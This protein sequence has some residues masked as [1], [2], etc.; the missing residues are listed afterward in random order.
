MFEDVGNF[1]PTGSSVFELFEGARLSD[2]DR[3]LVESR[4]V[5]I[6]RKRFEGSLQVARDDGDVGS[7]G[8]HTD[9]RLEGSH[10]SIPSP[11]A[12]GEQD[13]DAGFID[14]SSSELSDGVCS[15]LFSNYF[16]QFFRVQTKFLLY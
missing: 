9:S 14:E 15:D 4:D 10:G 16:Q 11:S 13:V 7:G 1:V 6:G 12:F 2:G 8:H 5:G 3:D